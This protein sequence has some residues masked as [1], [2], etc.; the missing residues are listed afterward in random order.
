MPDQRTVLFLYTRLPDYFYSCV[1]HFV[2]TYPCKAVIV[3]YKGDKDTNYT[4]APDENIQ[5]FYKDDLDIPV[6][7]QE[8]QPSAIVVTGWSDRIYTEATKKYVRRIPVVVTVDNPW[9]GILRQK[10]LA[11]LAPWA[12]HG[13]ANHAWVPGWS[14]YEYVRRL[15]FPRDK[16][17]RSMYCADTEKFYKTQPDGVDFKVD[18]YPKTIVYAGRLVEYKQPH[19]LAKVFN[20]MAEAGNSPWKLI[21]AGEGPLKKTIAEQKYSHVEILD[22]LNPA[23]LPEFYQRSGIF[24]LPS[25]DEHWG[26]AVH[27]AVAAGLP[28]LLSDTVESASAFLINGYN[29]LSFRTSDDS[30]LKHSLRF[31]M[32]MSAVELVR[33]GN[34]SVGLSK[35]IN[36]A[37]WSA[38]L[39]NVLN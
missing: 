9:Q 35:S 25:K 27:E 26:V 37:I 31:L 2:A 1:Q 33:M 15:G 6:F 30:S 14:Q 5:L 4:F 20:E 13:F 18:N 10:V 8:L 12:I 36:H 22:F 21:L 17:L 19:V 39:Y 16:I 38:T 28:V 32:N 24:C 34:N 23:M 7:I 29:G 11:T 3:R